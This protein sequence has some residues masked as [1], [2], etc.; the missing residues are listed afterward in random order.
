MSNPQNN[1]LAVELRRMQKDVLGRLD[2]ISGRIV[3]LEERFNDMHAKLFIDQGDDPCLAGRVRAVEKG[4]L[5]EQGTKTKW[6]AKAW[7][8]VELVFAALIGVAL[9][10]YRS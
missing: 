5:E 9:G 2:A 1:W 3:R 8:L 10:K 7:R 4:L 6:A